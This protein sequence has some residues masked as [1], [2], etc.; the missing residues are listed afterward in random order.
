MTRPLLTNPHHFFYIRHRRLFPPLGGGKLIFQ[1]NLL[2]QQCIALFGAIHVVLLEFCVLG[3]FGRE[4]DLGPLAP[5][6]RDFALALVKV[7]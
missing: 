2:R 4:L 5:I 3:F 7:I 1:I 6:R